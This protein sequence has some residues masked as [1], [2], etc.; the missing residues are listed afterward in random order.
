MNSQ[1]EDLREIKSCFSEI[2]VQ[3]KA[4]GESRKIQK[5]KNCAAKL[6]NGMLDPVSRSY[7]AS[8]GN[9]FDDHGNDKL[10][11]QFISLTRDKVLNYKDKYTGMTLMHYSCE[12]GCL[13]FLK[14]V[15]KARGP[16]FLIRQLS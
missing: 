8:L 13:R 11:S 2:L 12:Y 5:V 15:F 10:H 4:Y 14:A 1:E 9:R 7:K 6:S 16:N 3:I